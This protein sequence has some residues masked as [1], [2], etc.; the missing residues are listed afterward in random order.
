[1]NNTAKN[2]VISFRVSAADAAHIDEAAA[3]L[4]KPRHRSDFARAAT[5][6]LA[7]RQVPEPTKPLR[8][9]VRRKPSADVQVLTKLLGE[10]GKVGSNVNQMSRHANQG[11]GGPSKDIMH[12]IAADLLEIKCAITQALSGN[13]T[14]NGD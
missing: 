9:P 6:H 11:G 7:R 10:L 8:V 1:M 14:G 13:G 5:M 12:G 3:A 4:K 2:I